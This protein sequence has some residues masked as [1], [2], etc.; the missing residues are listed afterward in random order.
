MKAQIKAIVASAVVIALCLAAV[1]GVTYSWFSDTAENKITVN[2]AE[3][4]LE[5]TTI[6]GTLKSVGMND[7]QMVSNTGTFPLGGTVSLGQTSIGTESTTFNIIIDQMAPGDSIDLTISGTLKNTITSWMNTSVSITE[8]GIAYQDGKLKATSPTYIVDSQSSQGLIQAGSDIKDVSLSTT[9]SLDK[10]AGNNY[11]NRQFIITLTV[12]VVQ[13]N[14]EGNGGQTTVSSNTQEIS[15][16]YG[17]VRS[18]TKVTFAA[19]EFHEGEKILLKVETTDLQDMVDDSSFI[20]YDGLT[21]IATIDLN[22]YVNGDLKTSTFANGA[23]VQVPIP[24]EISTDDIEVKY[25]QDDGR[26]GEAEITVISIDN[27]ILTF[28]TNHFSKYVVFEKKNVVAINKDTE[29][30][31]TYDDLTGGSL[32]TGSPAV[33]PGDTVM[34]VQDISNTDYSHGKTISLA[35]GMIFDGNGHKISGNI[36][37]YCNVNGATIQ[38]VRFIGIHNDTPIGLSDIQKYGF[39]EGSTGNLSALYAS[40]LTGNLVVTGCV[41]DGTDWDSI[42]VTPKEGSVIYICDNVFSDNGKIIS[43][44]GH[45]TVRQIHIESAY[46]L[47]GVDFTVTVKNNKFNTAYGLNQ[48]ALE[49]YYPADESKVDISGNYISNLAVC[50]YKGGFTKPLWALPLMDETLSREIKPAGYE[51]RDGNY[52]F[53][54]N[55]SDLKDGNY[56]INYDDDGNAASST[57]INLFIDDKE[58]LLAFANEINIDKIHYSYKVMLR[59]NIDLQ[60]VEWIPIGQASTKQFIG[61]FDGNDHVISNLTINTSSNA[62]EGYSTGFFGLLKGTVKN[63]NVELTN[64]NGCQNVGVIAGS[65]ESSKGIIENCHVT[66]ATI[67]CTNANAGVIIGCADNYVSVTKCTAKDSSV[68]AGSNAGQIV[69]AAFAANVTECSATDVTVTI[70]DTDTGENINQEEIGKEP[71]TSPSI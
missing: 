37:V 12:N 13:I 15:I 22:L 2:A 27:G 10:S 19:G 28:K 3:I 67:T 14:Y 48:T 68:S 38:N 5:F 45:P 1:G 58:E 30:R 17:D 69:G 32:I 46:S 56:I 9:I 43:P 52:Y 70:N 8:N 59:S 34:M 42:Q 11:Q 16:P 51:I 71:E 31:Y 44:R 4:D 29:V 33:S 21:S 41:F 23:T 7:T 54:L 61:T 24:T 18:N 62:E 55:E 60:G 25:V 40:N 20:V 26:I 39:D 63:L 36:S 6:S 49:V 64:I 47:S 50:I 65:V 35:A 66:N 57:K 53:I